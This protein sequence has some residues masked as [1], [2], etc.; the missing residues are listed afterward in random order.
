M[1]RWRGIATVAGYVALAGVLAL[2]AFWL[3][4]SVDMALGF[5]PAVAAAQDGG[6]VT[7]ADRANTIDGSTVGEVL[8]DGDVVIRMRTSAGG[9]SAPERAMIIAQRIQDWVS[10]QYSPYDLA[11]REGMN[12][13]AELRA[14]GD[15]IVDVNPAEAGALGSTAMGL[16]NAWR[17]NIQMALGVEPAPG[18]PVV[19][20]GD[21][22]TPATGDD[23]GQQPPVQQVEYDSKI[24]PILSV[25]GSTA[26]G[27]ARI[28]GP[29]DKL[30]D[31]IACTQVEMTFQRFLEI[32]IYVPVKTRGG[33]DRVQQVGVTGLGDIEI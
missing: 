10:G 5:G 2:G 29:K 12:G 7:V 4:T 31:V 20:G 24:V 33:L 16:A 13:A 23:N 26:I 9:F 25:G 8:M 14:A 15:L 11:V 22:G 18:T 3:G 27:A 6:T 28:N 1:F 19:G 21:T 17:A 30:G 32:D